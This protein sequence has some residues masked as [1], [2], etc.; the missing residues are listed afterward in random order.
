MNTL[1][2]APAAPSISSDVPALE[3]RITAA[4]PPELLALAN[5]PRRLIERLAFC[6]V[7]RAALRDELPDAEPLARYWVKLAALVVPRHLP[8]PGEAAHIT[9][10]YKGVEHHLSLEGSFVDLWLMS[11]RANEIAAALWRGED[12]PTP[13][14]FIVANGRRAH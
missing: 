4:T 11:L 13:L 8:W 9:S 5:K 1:A 12:L 10:A 6:A 7:R 3:F 2:S 14:E